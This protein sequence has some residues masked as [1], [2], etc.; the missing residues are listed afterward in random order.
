MLP[1]H[2]RDLA[3]SEGVTGTVVVEASAWL[4]D[5]QWVLDLAADDPWIVGLVGHVDPDRDGFAADI[6]RFAA[7]ELF[8]GIRIGGGCFEDVDAGS[9]CPDMEVLAS[10][11][12]EL[13][14][15]MNIDYWDGLCTLASR[16]PELRIVINHLARPYVLTRT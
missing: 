10:S 4:D 2:H 6:E 8:R 3:A 12:L 11:D 5:N 15:L 9:F 13:D 1:E 14:V 16:L 7:N